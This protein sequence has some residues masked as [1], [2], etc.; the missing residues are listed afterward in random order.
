MKF[1]TPYLSIAFVFALSFNLSAQDFFPEQHQ[2][3]TQSYIAK[4][5]KQLNDPY[6]FK[7]DLMDEILFS[8]DFADSLTGNNGFG[9]WTR[10]GQHGLIWRW[11]FDGPDGPLI[12]NGVP[13]LS[14]TSENGFFIFD[15]D[16]ADP[17]MIGGIDRTGFLVSPVMDLT[18]AGSTI[19]QFQQFFNYCCYDF[20]PLFV[21]VSN[22]GG[23]TWVDLEATPGYTDG[24]NNF[25]D[26]PMLS[27]IDISPYAAGY[28]EVKIRFGY[29]PEELSGFTHYF[30]AVDDILIFVNPIEY[31]LAVNDLFLNDIT[32]DYEYLRIPEL[33]TNNQKF[34]VIVTNNGGLQQT[35]VHAVI[36][37]FD[38]FGSNTSYSSDT[39]DL[40]PG[41]RDTLF[42]TTSLIPED[43]GLYNCNVDVISDQDMD[44]EIPDNNMMGKSFN[45]TV[46]IMAHEHGTFFDDAKGS[47]PNLD[48]P[49]T[50]KKFALGSMFKMQTS[51]VLDGIQ[52]QVADSTAL[53]KTIY[54]V[55]YRVVSGGIQGNV[56]PVSGY[57]V[58]ALMDGYT[59][60]ED[61]LTGVAFNMGLSTTVTLDP[62]E[63]YMIALF[64]EAGTEPVYYKALLDGDSDLSTIRYSLD[65]FGNDNWFNGYNY[66]PAIRLNFDIALNVVE[67]EEVFS[68]V[69]TFP[70]PAS[71]FIEI[72][73]TTKSNELVSISIFDMTGK[74]VL[75]QSLG[76]IPNG[77]QRIKLNVEG[78]NSG[79]YFYELQQGNSVITNKFIV[80]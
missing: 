15:A 37:V 8:E 35:G 16:A 32:I 23:S 45:T 63:Y 59:I 52:A 12:Q 39:I 79:M 51:V 29:N 38:P 44:D 7:M 14:T 33:Q 68:D 48:N 61:D 28:S 42:L 19:L 26:N 43:L 53:G 41:V 46:N 25:S 64:S 40:A 50:Y 74:Q 62:D 1:F 17:A 76:A 18:D 5:A 54:P 55:I 2:A 66:T 72:K 9:P 4:E 69:K 60:T 49:G 10:E 47:R 77:E 73:F 56:F 6:S 34:T 13:L 75:D 67:Q 57:S 3:K 65:Q 21:G 24:A 30:W 78:L 20:T 27:N 11:D 22:D 36:T 58:D 70:N 71:D 31:D 80:K